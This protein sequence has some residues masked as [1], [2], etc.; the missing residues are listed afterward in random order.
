[1]TNKEQEI[2][3]KAV[4]E[5]GTRIQMISCDHPDFIKIKALIIDSVLEEFDMPPWHAKYQTF[6]EE[7]GRRLV[8]C[9]D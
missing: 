3:D 2:L 9:P 1:M 7:M 5:A 6:Q 4:G 8:F